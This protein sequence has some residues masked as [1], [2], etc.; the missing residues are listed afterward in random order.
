MNAETERV[1]CPVCGNEAQSGA[2]YSRSALTW[3][4]GKPSWKNRLGAGLFLLGKL[5]MIGRV[6]LIGAAYAEGIYCRSCNHIVLPHVS[7]KDYFPDVK[8]D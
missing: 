7:P 1:T 3:L 4:E 6:E 2:L 8:K 5:K